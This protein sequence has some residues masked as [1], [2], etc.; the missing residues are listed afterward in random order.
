MGQQMT[1]LTAVLISQLGNQA[2]EAQTRFR[3][4][5]GYCHKNL[6]MVSSLTGLCNLFRNW[7][8]AMGGHYAFAQRDTRILERL[9]GE[10]NASAELVLLQG[11]HATS[12]TQSDKLSSKAVIALQN[13]L[14]HQSNVEDQI[15]HECKTYGQLA[16]KTLKAAQMV[17]GLPDLSSTEEAVK[18]IVMAGEK[19][20]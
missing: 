4:D 8:K 15:K 5:Y 12:I 2:V 9:H 11:M 10:V 6:N 1:H 14:N 17:P 19:V 7:E 18:E 3:A 13:L 16:G 20:C